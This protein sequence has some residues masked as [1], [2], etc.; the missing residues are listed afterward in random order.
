MFR[1]GILACRLARSEQQI[2]E[3]QKHIKAAVRNVVVAHVINAS[4]L[5]T[6]RKPAVHVNPPV[7]L[8]GGNQIEHPPNEDTWQNSAETDQSTNQERW[9]SIDGEQKDNIRRGADKRHMFRFFGSTDLRMVIV[10]S[11]SE[12]AARPVQQPAVIDVFESV[13]PDHT[14]D[15]P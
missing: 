10:M 12:R 9:N 3:R 6:R 15:E 13:T 14:D 4:E 11:N 7:D 2:E 8:F 5:K 1:F